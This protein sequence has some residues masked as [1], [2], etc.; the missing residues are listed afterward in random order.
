MFLQCYTFPSKSKIVKF[1][2]TLLFFI[3][4][5]MNFMNINKKLWKTKRK[6]DLN[7]SIKAQNFKFIMV[8]YCDLGSHGD[9]SFNSIIAILAAKGLK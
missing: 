5:I 4:E 6:S 2:F 8:H 9:C 7:R 3:K 1:P